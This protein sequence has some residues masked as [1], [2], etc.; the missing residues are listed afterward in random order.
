MA[1]ND[2]KPMTDGDIDPPPVQTSFEPAA[3][4]K[5][6]GVEFD[7]ARRDGATNS[8]DDAAS[9]APHTLRERAGQY[10]SQAADRARTLADTGKEKASGALAQLST[11][12]GD[13]AG[14]V[15]GKLGAQYGDYARS[16]AGTV[17]TFADQLQAKD[18]DELIEDARS[19]VKK[20]PGV[21]IGVAAALGFVVARLVQ[22]GLDS[23]R[24]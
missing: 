11:M 5:D 23:N 10:G 24:D 3:P 4:L 15:D 12:I 8:G 21:A 9:Q 16:A 1:D 22:S 17:Q 18:V 7:A 20:S 6:T 19:F 14:Q 2:L 13:A